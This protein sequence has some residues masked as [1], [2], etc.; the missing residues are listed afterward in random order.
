MQRSFFTLLTLLLL[1]IGQTFAQGPKTVYS[2]LKGKLS[3]TPLLYKG[4]QIVVGSGGGF[5]GESVSYYLL[6]NG[7]LF[8]KRSTDSTF[9]V[10]SKQTIANTQRTFRLLENGCKI[11]SAKFD[12]P[13]NR[14][15]F[16]SWKKGKQ[17]H[18]VKWGDPKH[19]VPAS[20]NQFYKSFMAMIPASAR[21]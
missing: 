13:G 4:R 3:N 19:T 20:Y 15:Y 21:L 17:E 11:K 2:S 1:G 10:V 12:H 9:H 6:D 7:T 8:A 18:A 14:Y 5:T 16:V